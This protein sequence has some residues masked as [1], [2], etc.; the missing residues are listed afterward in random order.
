MIC[1]YL[2]NAYNINYYVLMPIFVGTVWEP[3]CSG[4]RFLIFLTVY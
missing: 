2:L 1:L 4:F 3:V